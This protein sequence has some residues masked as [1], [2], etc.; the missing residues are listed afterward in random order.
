LVFLELSAAQLPHAITG[1]LFLRE[2][3]GIPLA[4]LVIL[5]D[6]YAR[7]FAAVRVSESSRISKNRRFVFLIHSDVANAL[8]DG[9]CKERAIA[10]GAVF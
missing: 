1:L 2:L 5:R 10:Q 6:S 9:S 3:Q 8:K 7:A 4:N